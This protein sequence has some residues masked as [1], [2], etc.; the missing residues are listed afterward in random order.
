[1]AKHPRAISHTGL[2]S[3][4]G[5]PAPTAE[6]FKPPQ[7]LQEKPIKGKFPSL[8]TAVDP[9]QQGP[10]GDP[11]LRSASPSGVPPSPTSAHWTLALP[12]PR[13]VPAAPQGT[14]LDQE[15]PGQGLTFYL[16]GAG[17]GSE[18]RRLV[19]QVRRFTHFPTDLLLQSPRIHIPW[20]SKGPGD[21]ARGRT[22]GNAHMPKHTGAICCGHSSTGRLCRTKGIKPPGC[23]RGQP[24]DPCESG[25]RWG[26]TKIVSLSEAHMGARLAHSGVGRRAWLGGRGASRQPVL[27][28]LSQSLSP[29]QGLHTPRLQRDKGPLR[30]QTQQGEGNTATKSYFGIFRLKIIQL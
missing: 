11:G 7:T 3:C 27:P 13:G 1:M 6:V 14:A 23:G 28:G 17:L 24:R 19:W 22:P 9:E 8:H 10:S 15:H 20:L 2:P 5:P 12:T 29:Q 18:P 4:Q 16:L 21:S 26:L 30:P 25:V